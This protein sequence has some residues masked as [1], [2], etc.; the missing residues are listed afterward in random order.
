MITMKLQTTTYNSCICS[1]SWCP[2]MQCISTNTHVWGNHFHVIQIRQLLFG[3]TLPMDGRR[4]AYSPKAVLGLQEQA[5][6]GNSCHRVGSLPIV[7]CCL[8]PLDIPRKVGTEK[9]KAS[10][11]AAIPSAHFPN[12]HY[13]FWWGHHPPGNLKSR[14]RH[15][16]SAE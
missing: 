8:S 4:I 15:C 13:E 9:Q 2:C 11:P 6:N 1:H 3:R 14:K 10:S 12:V 7:N 16:S 5:P